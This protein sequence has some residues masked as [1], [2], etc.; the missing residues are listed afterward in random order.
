MKQ[1]MPCPTI[2]IWVSGPLIRG[3]DP[4]GGAIDYRRD[5]LS[6]TWDLVARL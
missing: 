6:L 2:T 5:C 1:W 3:I 4:L